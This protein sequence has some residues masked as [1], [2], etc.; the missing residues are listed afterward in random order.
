[1]RITL[2][3][4]DEQINVLMCALYDGAKAYEFLAE[5]FRE[6]GD[7]PEAERTENRAKW[8]YSVIDRMKEEKG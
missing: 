7:L 3:L 2:D 1:M 4:T 6:A 5:E 8:V